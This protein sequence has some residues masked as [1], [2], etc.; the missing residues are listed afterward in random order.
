LG[1]DWLLSLGAT[2]GLENR[3]GATVAPNAFQAI[4]TCAL[5]DSSRLRIGAEYRGIGFD[6]ESIR[7]LFTLDTR[8]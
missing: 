4:V 3:S 2:V 1:D 8:I 7:F 5:G 6:P